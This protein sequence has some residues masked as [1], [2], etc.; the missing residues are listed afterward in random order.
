MCVFYSKDTEV[1]SGEQANM[2]TRLMM[3][4]KSMSKNDTWE[5]TFKV[6]YFIFVEKENIFQMTIKQHYL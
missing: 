1:H 2:N 3:T 4:G 5:N 6:F